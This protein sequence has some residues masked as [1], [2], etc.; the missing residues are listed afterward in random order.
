MR[1]LLIL[2]LSMQCVHCQ[3]KLAKTNFNSSTSYTETN[4]KDNVSRIQNYSIDSIN[5]S[6]IK[7]SIM[8]SIEVKKLKK[9]F[10]SAL[11]RDFERPYMWD[12][13]AGSNDTLLRFYEY[14]DI[15]LNKKQNLKTKYIKI[16]YEDALYEALMLISDVNSEHYSSLIVYEKLESEESYFRRLKIENDII[17]IYF[18]NQVE[19]SSFF[20]Y[21]NDLF[22]DYFTDITVNR[23]WKKNTDYYELKGNTKNH[24]KEGYWIEK[25]YS[26]DKN[27]SVS[28]EGSYSQGIRIG[29]W[30]ISSDNV[31]DKIVEYKNG[32]IFSIK[33]P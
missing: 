30:Y 11:E 14:S 31:L 21:K 25:K 24:L 12:I 5:T 3:K 10:K 22:L 28:E 7:G 27:E 2:I 8:D 29:Q 18:N 23:K 1:Y 33:Y 9:L 4:S 26:F 17:K 15:I 19:Y 32:K 13:F 6:L 16:E 20:I